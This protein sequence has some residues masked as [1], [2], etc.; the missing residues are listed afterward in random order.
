MVLETNKIEPNVL[1]YYSMLI[2]LSES[3]CFEHSNF[4]KVKSP[5]PPRRAQGPTGFPEAQRSA[6]AVRGILPD[7]TTRPKVQL[8]A[9]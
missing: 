6:P 4:F 5:G 2:Y 8:R 3:A 7:R 1:F 9:F